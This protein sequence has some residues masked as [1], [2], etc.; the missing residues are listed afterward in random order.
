MSRAKH[1]YIYTDPYNTVETKFVLV[2]PTIV[3]SQHDIHTLTSKHA[4][5]LSRRDSLEHMA[6]TTSNAYSAKRSKRQAVPL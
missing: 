2:I 4:G 1:Y 3:G 6:A 5:A